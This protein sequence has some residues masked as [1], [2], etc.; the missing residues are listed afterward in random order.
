MYLK[1]TINPVTSTEDPAI[2]ID[3]SSDEE[4]GDNKQ[5]KV[6][7]SS[8]TDNSSATAPKQPAVT[9][10]PTANG[11]K[12]TETNFN[13][14]LNVMRP[15]PASQKKR[16]LEILD[17]RP[18]TSKNNGPSGGQQPLAPKPK[19]FKKEVFAKK[20]LVTFADVGGMDKALKELCELILHIKHPEMYKH[21][22]LPPP[23]GFLLH[24]APGT[25]ELD[26]A[27]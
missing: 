16:R 23:R 11:T 17:E 13:E 22:G 9:I 6:V 14:L 19:K 1:K 10:I 24:G 12:Q 2:S 20:S 15:G 7:Q 18:E 8:A 21:I 27:C 5:E 26:C 25:G 4:D 3:I